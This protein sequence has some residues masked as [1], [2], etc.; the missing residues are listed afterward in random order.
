MAN[1][2][3]LINSNFIRQMVKADVASDKHG[4]RVVTRFPPEPNGYLHIGHAK[5]ICLN[6][7]VA[8]EFGGRCHLRFDDTNP[9]KEDMKYVESIQED[10]R[11]LGFDWGEH[12]YFAS[13]YYEQLY[14]FGVKLIE[15]GLAFVCS[16]S[17]S[18]VRATRGTVKEPG[19]PSPDR[20]RSTEENLDLFARMKA[21][22]FEDG[23]YTLRAKIDMSAP[24][25]KLRDPPLYRIRK[26]S[27]YR[28]GDDWCIYPFYDFAHCLSDAIEG[29]THSLCSLEFENNRELYDWLVGHLIDSDAPPEQTEFARLNLTHTVMSKRKLLRLV[30]DGKV[31]GW[32]DPRLM[33]LAALRRRGY[34]PEAIREF[35]EKVGVARRNSVVD[36]ALLESTVRDDLNTTT[37]RVMAVL[38]PLKLVITNYPEDQEDVF[39]APNFPDDPPKMGSREIPFGKE[40]YIE[41]TDF[42][43][44]APKKF[45]R[46]SVGREVRLRWAYLV[47]CTGFVKDDDGNV[48]EVHCTYD[49]ETRGGSPPDGRRVKGT[50][51]W[52]SAKHAVEA[53][54][55][56]YE[57]LLLDDEVADDEGDFF[58]QLNDKSEVVIEN[59][60]VERSLGGTEAGQRYQ[61]ERTGYFIADP[62]STAERPVFNRTVPLRDSWAKIAKQSGQSKK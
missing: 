37:P 17:E 56:L 42:M 25:M 58:E 52:V 8:Q 14:Q 59:A 29:V 12:L 33:T 39:E 7:G 45:F 9:A 28:T 10:I 6:F 51:H 27:H 31:R 43:E 49:P 35:C 26:I 19:T 54:V 57:P 30:Q 55:R 24:N 50:I 21:G 22:E 48:V 62:D 34:R 1:D 15:K 40:I 36:M 5:A 20:D 53:E 11:W 38:N 47:T 13:D 32:D 2:N 46:L 44:D 4:G 61:F 60:K 41:A 18:E 16:Q 23:K 3:E